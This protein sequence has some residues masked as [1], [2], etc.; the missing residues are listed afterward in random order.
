MATSLC[1]PCGLEGDIKNLEHHLSTSPKSSN[2]R[3]SHPCRDGESSVADLE[4]VAATGSTRVQIGDRPITAEAAPLEEASKRPAVP[5]P[6]QT[7]ADR[8]VGPH[9]QHGSTAG[10]ADQQ[11]QGQG[12]DWDEPQQSQS[13]SVDEAEQVSLYRFLS[14]CPKFGVAEAVLQQAEWSSGGRLVPHFSMRD[15]ISHAPPLVPPQAP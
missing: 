15:A 11:Q 9:H 3:C 5:L 8:E 13:P 4:D 1:M 2:L 6:L 14:F 10:G 12:G 7:W